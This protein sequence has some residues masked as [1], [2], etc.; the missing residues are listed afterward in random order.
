M[1]SSWIAHCEPLEE[2]DLLLGNE[3]VGSAHEYRLQIELQTILT[4]F[5]WQLNRLPAKLSQ[6]GL[7][8]C[9]R[10][11][12]SQITCTVQTSGRFTD[13]QEKL[14]DKLLSCH[15]IEVAEIFRE[16]RTTTLQ[17]RA[18]VRRTTN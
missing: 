13:W 18:A 12:T 2:I 17:D 11:V 15:W 14:P 7:S 4:H 5:A 3:S 10:G 6:R 9:D 1:A 8:F 16:V